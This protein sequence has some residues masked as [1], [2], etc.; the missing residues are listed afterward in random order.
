MAQSDERALE[1][2]E[3][4]GGRP[5]TPFFEDGPARYAA[6][7]LDRAGVPYERD[8]FGNIIARLQGEASRASRR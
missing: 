2:L 5:A 8:D 3:G 4:L 6:A 1:L 7:V